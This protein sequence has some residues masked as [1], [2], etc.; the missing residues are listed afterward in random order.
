MKYK[1][2]HFHQ[3]GLRP[4]Q[5]DAYYIDPENRYFV[6]C[7]GIGGAAHGALAS[8]IVTEAI[9]ERIVH[10]GVPQG[11]ND[12]MELLDCVWRDFMEFYRQ[13]PETKDMGTTLVVAF[14]VEKGILVAH[15]GDSR[16]YHVRSGEGLLWRTKDHSEVQELYDA[17]IIPSM[18]AMER[19]PRRNVI[20]RAFLARE[21][22][23]LPE[24]DYHL[25]RHI[26]PGDILMLCTDGVLEPFSQ[27]SQVE[28]LTDSE[29]SLKEK[30]EM[31]RR[32]CAEASKDN[33]TAVFVEWI[34]KL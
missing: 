3:Q 29:L 28:I 11:Q 24:L 5:E 1:I 2:Y 4:Y 34:G 10:F 32:K 25:I 21:G 23:E 17:G 31:I 30:T 7:D 26:H 8:E 13:R 33:N 12:A 18:E 15:V 19:H 16:A 14:V 22:E 9:K 6:V 27:D 20:T